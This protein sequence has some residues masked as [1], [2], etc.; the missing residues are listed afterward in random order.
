MTLA[1]FLDG[2]RVAKVLFKTYLQHSQNSNTAE[3]A[4]TTLK[5][6]S[7]TFRNDIGFDDDQLRELV[8]DLNDLSLIQG[9]TETGREDLHFSIHSLVQDWARLRLPSDE[10]R[11]N[12]REAINIMQSL[13]ETFEH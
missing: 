8:V 11:S 10:Q 2:H 1:A 6:W 5:G 13:F 9:F 7:T 4:S 12:S 3:D